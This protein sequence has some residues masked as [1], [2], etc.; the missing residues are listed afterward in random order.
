MGNRELIEKVPNAEF[1]N[2]VIFRRV[3]PRRSVRR[4]PCRRRAVFARVSVMRFVEQYDRPFLVER[5]GRN[6]FSFF[7]I[8]TTARARFVLGIVR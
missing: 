3:V 5:A 6:I 1:S 4:R 7:P 8:F 2:G